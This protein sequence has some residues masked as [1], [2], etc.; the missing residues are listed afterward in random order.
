MHCPRC[1]HANRP[2][3]TFC[4]AC[5]GPLKEASLVTRSHADELKAEVET[6][7]QALTQAVEQQRASAELVQTRDG[8]L[9]KSLEQQTATAEILRVISSSPTDVQPVF[10]MIVRS[11]ARLCGG[12]SS[13]VF[14]VDGDMLDVAA[15][16]PGRTHPAL[17]ALP[18]A[19]SDADQR[20]NAAHVAD[21]NGARDA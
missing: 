8:E 18:A 21:A 16:F 10:A 7:R 4:E 5:A 3:A 20:P 1:Q 13:M 2:Q 6:L 14:R 11:A 17:D 9:A 19:L 15:A 12:V